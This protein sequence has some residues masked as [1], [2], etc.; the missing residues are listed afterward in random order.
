[1]RIAF[2]KLQVCYLI[3][4][5]LYFAET[6]FGVIKIINHKSKIYMYLVICADFLIFAPSMKILNLKK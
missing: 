5:Y 3:L 6:E 4:L 1:M 2:G